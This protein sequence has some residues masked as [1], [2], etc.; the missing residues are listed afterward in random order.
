MADGT[1]AIRKH[2]RFDVRLQQMVG[3]RKRWRDK[4]AELQRG[5]LRFR[6]RRA[7]DSESD[8]ETETEREK[9]RGK[10]R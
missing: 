7:S 1:A 9:E 8:W 2:D 10:G 6:E 3:W 4:G 5:V